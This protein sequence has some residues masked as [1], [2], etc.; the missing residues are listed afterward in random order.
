MCHL[1]QDRLF[2]PGFMIVSMIINVHYIVIHLSKY[3]SVYFNIWSNLFFS[4]ITEKKIKLLADVTV[5]GEYFIW[6][7]LFIYD[8]KFMKH[9]LYCF[10]NICT[11]RLNAINYIKPPYFKKGIT[12]CFQ[13]ICLKEYQNLWYNRKLWNWSYT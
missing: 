7:I 10:F 1:I 13:R 6:I 9:K 5:I 3:T 4:V 8:Q 11:S 2:I 12:I